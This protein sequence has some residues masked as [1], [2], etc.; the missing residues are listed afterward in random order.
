VILYLP[1]AACAD[2]NPHR[3]HWVGQCCAS[4][5]FPGD[6][7]HAHGRHLG[8]V[9]IGRETGAFQEAN[10]SPYQSTVQSTVNALAGTF[11]ADISVGAPSLP[12]PRK[13]SFSR[14]NQ[15]VGI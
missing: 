5:R 8:A 2:S 1:P 11:R 9:T 6:V 13:A 4:L 7:G 12:Q 10:P 15:R 14:G 3:L